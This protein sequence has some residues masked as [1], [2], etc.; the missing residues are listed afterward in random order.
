MSR[1]ARSR[2][3]RLRHTDP[4]RIA[5][6]P[7]ASQPTYGFDS[8]NAQLLGMQKGEEKSLNFPAR[9]HIT[10]IEVKVGRCEPRLAA[11]RCGA[12]PSRA[13]R[14]DRLVTLCSAAAPEGLNTRRRHAY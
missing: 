11:V 1:P 12:A 2:A 8:R 7:P 10:A 14:S 3:V 9:D 4:P 13:V 6:P 5:I